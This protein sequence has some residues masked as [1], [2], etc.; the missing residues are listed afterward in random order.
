MS[1][2]YRELVAGHEVEHDWPATQRPIVVMSRPGTRND[3]AYLTPDE[4][5]R[6]A[7]ALVKAAEAAES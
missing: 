2:Q 6:L 7:E 1:T 3:P 4:A 5:R